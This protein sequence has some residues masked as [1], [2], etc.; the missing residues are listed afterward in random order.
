[1]AGPTAVALAFAGAG[2]CTVEFLSKRGEIPLDSAIASDQDVVV[3]GKTV[4]GQSVAQEFAEPPLHPVADDGVPDL[5]GD[6]D[7]VTGFAR[8][9]GPGQQDEAWFRIAQSA[10]GREEIGPLAHH[11]DGKGHSTLIRERAPKREPARPT[12]RPPVRRL[13]EGKSP[14]RLC[15]ERK[16]RAEVLAATCA[17]S[18]KHLAATGGRLAREETVATGAHEVGRLESPLHGLEPLS[19]W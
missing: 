16:L 6:R 2:K 4:A 3:A 12:G 13:L 15:R 17:T 14:G 8:I 10:I 11:F 7:A 1:M 9:V 5:L 19:I 18:A